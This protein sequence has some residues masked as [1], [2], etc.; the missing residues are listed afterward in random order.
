MRWPASE[1]ARARLWVRVC[2][3]PA[4]EC[5]RHPATQWPLSQR[6]AGRCRQ[7][8]EHAGALDV[9]GDMAAAGE[10][11]EEQHVARREGPLGA[12]ALDPHHAAAHQEPLAARAGVPADSWL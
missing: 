7:V 4:S 1:G 5:C 9:A 3:P 6:E 12:L 11:V 2:P 10:V 8:G